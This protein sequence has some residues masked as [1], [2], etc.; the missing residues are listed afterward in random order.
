MRQHVTASPRATRRTLEIVAPVPLGGGGARAGVRTGVRAGLP[1]TRVPVNAPGGITS[2]S[3]RPPAWWWR[4]IESRRRRGSG[5]LQ[6]R[7]ARNRTRQ[8]RCAT[9]RRKSHPPARH[10]EGRRVVT[11]WPQQLSAKS[12]AQERPP[13]GTRGTSG[14][15]SRVRGGER[16]A[17]GWSFTRSTRQPVRADRGRRPAA[18]TL[19]P[20]RRTRW[21]PTANKTP[22]PRAGRRAA[23][24]ARPGRGAPRVVFDRGRQTPTTARM[25]PRDRGPAPAGWSLI[26]SQMYETRP[27]LRREAWD[28]DP[29]AWRGG[30]G[31]GEPRRTA[32]RRPGAGAAKETETSTS[33]ASFRSTGG[34]GSQGWPPVRFTALSCGRRA[35]A[36]VGAG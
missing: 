34:Q 24:R 22:A 3:R 13:P 19:A 26:C 29:R 31:G 28:A 10:G 18:V 1:A 8:G 33:K 9:N 6:V 17:A 16:G 14:C 4:G 2:G 12:G 25:R 23:R 36:T 35:T 5:N 30:G 15:A 7:Q 27:I 11:T 32:G 21:T 20:A